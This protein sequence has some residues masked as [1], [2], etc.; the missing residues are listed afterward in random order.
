[1]NLPTDTARTTLDP[2]D[3]PAMRQQGHRMLDDMFDYIEHIRERPVWQPI[4]SEVR[5]AFCEPLPTQPVSLEHA[6]E[7]F[8]TQVLPYAVGNTHPGF[9]G[10]VHG[11]GT[12]VGM[13]AEMLAAGL[14]ANLGGR[15]Q[16]PLEVERQIGLW[17]RELFGFPDSSAGLFVTG[18]ST[19][20]LMGVLVA[21]TQALGVASRA[22]G[23]A[24]GQPRLTAYAASSAHGCITKAMDLCGLGTQALRLVAVNE[25]GQMDVNALV[26]MIAADRA[27]GLQPFFVA[28]TAGTVNIGAIDPL[29]QVAAIAA[30]QHLWFHV[31]GA[32][33]A[34]GMLSP[35]VAPRLKG[36]E[37]ADSIALDFH[38]WGQVPYDAG[39]FLVRNGAD[40]LDAFASPAAYLAHHSRGLAAGSPWPCDMGPD[41]SRGFRALKTWFTFVCHGTAQ[42]GAVISRSCALAQ[43][44]AQ[45][46]QATPE[47][48]LMAPVALN[49]VCYRYQSGKAN[50]VNGEIVVLLHESGVAVPSASSIDGHTV[51]RAALVNHRT[52]AADVD[53]LLQATLAFG[54]T[55]TAAHQPS[56]EHLPK[57]PMNPSHPPLMGLAKLMRMAF[58]GQSLMPLADALK[59]RAEQDASDANALMDLSTA[60]QLHGLRDVGLS[61][62]ALALQSSRLYELSAQRSPALRLLAIMGPGDL[63]ANAPLPFLLENADVSLSMLYLLPGEPLPVS[64]PEHDV[65]F[66]AISDSSQTHALLAQLAQAVPTWPKPVLVRPEG[67]L[68]TSRENAYALLKDAP[69]VY[70]PPTAQTTRQALE[71]Y[72]SGHGVLQD[73]LPGGAFPLIIRPLDSH[74][75][76][77]LEKVDNMAALAQYLAGSAESDFFMASFIDYSGP[78]GLY[79]KYRVVL[80]DGV[81]F[82][83]HMGVSSH[84]MI[85]YLNAGMVES[86]EK[87]AEEEAFMRDFDTGFAKRQQLGLQSVQERFG[88]DYLVMDCAETPDGALFVFEVDA[89]AVVHAMDPPDMFPY[90][91]PAMQKVFDA[92]RAMLGRSA[93]AGSGRP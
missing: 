24:A 43:Y 40:Q 11:G 80:I 70:V 2:Q 42:L 71:A 87:R 9:M 31:D 63:M 91:V 66:I 14:N 72:C 55:L 30:Q 92:F 45:R 25:Q 85:H 18:S 60:L 32:L 50:E 79:R 29:A 56:H 57:A 51:I 48:E 62:L 38:K 22:A 15:D 34:L 89:G 8:M 46:I 88:L 93:A 76:H 44:M 49:I 81:P 67:I 27:A 75:G 65:A 4:P 64:L 17:M 33:G 35:D 86:A 84:W 5:Q 12:P 52:V 74:A 16:M 20:N 7:K 90:K 36:I 1:M 23:V 69:G 6:H 28:A 21:R 54:K 19:A 41:L 77:G 73:V 3:W 61:T 47:L 68:R 13:L 59:A 53:A 78:D 39:Y 26:G 37:L 83:G 82:A 10:W 58:Q